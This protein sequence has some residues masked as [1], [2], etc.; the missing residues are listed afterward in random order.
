MLLA[1]PKKCDLSFG[2][3]CVCFIY[4]KREHTE[5]KLHKHKQDIAKK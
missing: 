3:H 1:G 4:E 2:T 5:R